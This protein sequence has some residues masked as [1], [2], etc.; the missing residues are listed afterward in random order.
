M[1]IKCIA[2][3]F[4]MLLM[5]AYIS[6]AQQIKKQRISNVNIVNAGNA[7]LQTDTTAIKLHPVLKKSSN[8]LP[9]PNGRLAKNPA[10]YRHLTSTS[11]KNI[12]T[13][14]YDVQKTR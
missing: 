3:A 14:K 2:Y 13:M 8:V 1:T 9:G 12:S 10:A 6:S 4:G 11:G 7:K 5:T